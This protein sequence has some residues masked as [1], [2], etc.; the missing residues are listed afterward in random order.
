[1]LFAPSLLNLIRILIGW[2]PGNHFISIESKLRALSV[3]KLMKTQK[4]ELSTHFLP[5][6]SRYSNVESK[7]KIQTRFYS[8]EYKYAVLFKVSNMLKNTTYFWSRLYV[9]NLLG[10][11]KISWI[12]DSDWQWEEWQDSAGHCL[13]HVQVHCC[14]SWCISNKSADWN[15]FW[16]WNVVLSLFYWHF[17]LS[18]KH[19]SNL[20]QEGQ[21]LNLTSSPDY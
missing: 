3:Y 7:T 5:G 13:P 21:N 8:C 10:K 16:T 20:C 15:I 12:V 19:T 18:N 11:N 1:M 17:F 14:Y 4:F 6:V 2:S 9:N